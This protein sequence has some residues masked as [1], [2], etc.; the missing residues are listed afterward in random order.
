MAVVEDWDWGYIECTQLQ[1][2]SSKGHYYFRQIQFY[3]SYCV[4]KK[5]VFELTRSPGTVMHSITNDLSVNFQT[6]W[7]VAQN[8]DN[9][10]M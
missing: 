2:F 5:S 7:S 1:H 10:G 6:R 4:L 8:S 3:K 9:L